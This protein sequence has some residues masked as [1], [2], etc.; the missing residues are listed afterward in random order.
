MPNGPL[1]LHELSA[2]VQS[3]VEQVLGKHGAVPIDKLWVGF[4]A[5]DKIATPEI[6]GKVAVQL[7]RETGVKA[8]GSVAQLAP[9]PVGAPVHGQQPQALVH[10]GHI[11]G[12]VF[13]PTNV[14]KL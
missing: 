9:A 7:A 2:A 12:L 1:A 8:E 3:A 11:I 10:P 4:V 5:P 14:K 6:A 13:S